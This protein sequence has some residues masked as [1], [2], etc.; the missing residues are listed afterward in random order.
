[1]TSS[2]SNQQLKSSKVVQSPSVPAS[3][4]ELAPAASTLPIP[5]GLSP[6]FKENSRNVLLKMIKNE[7]KKS[8]DPLS[9][10]IGP[11]TPALN[12]SQKF[13]DT[14]FVRLS[15]IN[16]LRDVMR[17]IKIVHDDNFDLIEFFDDICKKNG[18]E[19]KYD[20]KF[21]NDLYFGELFIETFRLTTEKNRKKKKCKFNTY[22]KAF[23]ILISQSEL[24]VKSAKDQSFEYELYVIDI[25]IS[26]TSDKS[27]INDLNSMLR[28]MSLPKENVSNDLILNDSKESQCEEENEDEDRKSPPSN[29]KEK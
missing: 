10:L 8:N 22:K 29:K 2:S 26:S 20:Q 13:E 11:G 23:D 7:N 24:A 1:M 14:K 15:K 9:V 4:S 17:S 21:E 28:S 3:T 12:I 16:K 25:N 19:I 6:N 27:N 18:I 5:Y